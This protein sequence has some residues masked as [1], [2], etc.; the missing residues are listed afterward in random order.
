MTTRQNTQYGSGIMNKWY[1]KTARHTTFT[2]LICSEISWLL[3]NLDDLSSE[4]DVLLRECLT[5]DQSDNFLMMKLHHCFLC[6]TCHLWNIHIRKH[7]YFFL[8]GKRNHWE[9]YQDSGKIHSYMDFSGRNSFSSSQL[10]DILLHFSC[11]K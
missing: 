8:I 10:H 11:S 2:E 4:D 5:F 1:L 6:L 3:K 9:A 7:F